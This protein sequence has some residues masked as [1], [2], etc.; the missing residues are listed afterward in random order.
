MQVVAWAVRA[1][2]LLREVLQVTC[3]GAAR[4]P[5]AH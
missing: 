4:E 1:K 3:L 5:P 2:C